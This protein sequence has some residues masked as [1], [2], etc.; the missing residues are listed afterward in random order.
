[1]PVV[2]ALVLDALLVLLGRLLMPW[3][4]IAKPVKS[5]TGPVVVAASA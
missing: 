3:A 5:R 2:I 4:R 1:M